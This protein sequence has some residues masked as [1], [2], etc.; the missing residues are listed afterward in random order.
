MYFLV[1]AKAGTLG[2]SHLT[3]VALV[4]PVL[5]QQSPHM[6]IYKP[7][8]ANGY[9]K[10]SL[11]SYQVSTGFFFT[12]FTNLSTP[13]PYVKHSHTTDVSSQT[14]IRIHSNEPLEALSSKY[15]SKKYPKTIHFSIFFF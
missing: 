8:M 10:K 7:I 13:S 1:A 11:I 4:R 2:E 5:Q 12:T 9:G 15:K 6:L 14:Q 3:D